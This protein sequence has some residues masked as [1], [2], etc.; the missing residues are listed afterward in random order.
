MKI[1]QRQQEE[2]KRR[3]QHRSRRS[4]RRLQQPGIQLPEAELS[5]RVGKDQR[6]N[7]EELLVSTSYKEPE[8][9]PVPAQFQKVKPPKT[10]HKRG[11]K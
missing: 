9:E 6:R 4:L 5:L 2:E 10:H 7:N 11:R 3:Q 1:K 8:Q